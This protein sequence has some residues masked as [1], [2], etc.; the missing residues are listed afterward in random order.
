MGAL[1]DRMSARVGDEDLLEVR[2]AYGEDDLVTLQQLPI[3]RNGAVDEVSPVEE[4]L[5]AR[6]EVLGE[7]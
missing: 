6:R 5:K 7:L 3:A 4:A 1:T 2:T